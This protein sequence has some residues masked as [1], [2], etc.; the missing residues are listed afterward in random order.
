[1]R[2]VVQ[3]HSPRLLQHQQLAAVAG[4]RSGRLSEHLGEHFAHDVGRMTLAVPKHHNAPSIAD[5][6]ALS[7]FEVELPSLRLS[8]QLT[9]VLTESV[10]LKSIKRPV[11]RFAIDK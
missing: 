11:L 7:I 2:S 9:E 6:E 3:I 1:M 4:T 10:K 8:V 5:V